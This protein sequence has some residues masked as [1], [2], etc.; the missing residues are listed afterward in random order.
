MIE[1]LSS[2]LHSVL[3]PAF[4]IVKFNLYIIL[5]RIYFLLNGHHKS[6]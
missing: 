6:M 1:G 4:V 5:D 3:L 2:Q